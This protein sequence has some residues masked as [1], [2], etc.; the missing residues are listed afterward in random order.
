MSSSSPCDVIVVGAGILGISCALTLQQ[1]G[2]QVL[3]IDKKPPVSETSS[4]LAGVI[5]N[6][7]VLPLA[8]PGL[9]PSIPRLFLNRD[10]KFRIRHSQLHMLSPW[11]YRFLKYCNPIKHKACSNALGYLLNQALEPHLEWMKMTQSQSLLNDTG[12]LRL[13]NKG[14]N[15]P[16]QKRELEAYDAQGVAYQLLH[17]AEIKQLEPGLKRHYENAIW[18]TNTPS[19]RNPRKLSLNYF[20]HFIQSG[21]RFE[22]M[23]ARALKK[24]GDD[25][26]I[27]MDQSSLN[28]KKVV[29]C[30]GAWS[31]N[32]LATL[33]LKNPIVMERGYHYMIQP[34]NE[35]SLG[36]SIID[37]DRGLV[38][39]PM[40]DGI[41]VSSATE[42]VARETK[43]LPDQLRSLIPDML[44]ILEFKE[45]ESS[46]REKTP[47]MGRRP[48]TPDSLPIIG[49]LDSHRGLWFAFGHGHLGFTLGPI[50]A[51]I[52]AQSIQQGSLVQEYQAF[53]PNRFYD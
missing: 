23:E 50:T 32:I 43:P 20:E 44:D 53:S 35:E 52:I 13:Y 25:W 15:S 51:R 18:L 14:A 47:W 5:C 45:S 9:I 37:T 7:G 39:T 1:R 22:Q 8:S 46:I 28:A 34:E 17:S 31:S 36:R 4:G 38:M 40:Q 12:W 49:E 26:I 2:Y 30:M 11:L 27:K 10:S 16:A 19:V 6:S 33:N 41:R 3:L 21:G 24:Q 48:S 29:I 42:L